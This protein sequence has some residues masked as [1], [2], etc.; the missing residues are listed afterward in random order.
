[1]LAEIETLKRI[2]EHLD[3][4]RLASS[5]RELAELIGRLEAQNEPSNP[6]DDQNEHYLSI[7]P[8]LIVWALTALFFAV[9]VLSGCAKPEP[10]Y[11]GWC[12][13][14]GECDAST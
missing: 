4:H 1:M 2:A 8:L 13:R 5:S 6:I 9:I 10:E 3:Q 7:K 14:T 12:V 11:M